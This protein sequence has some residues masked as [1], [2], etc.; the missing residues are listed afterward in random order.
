L[1]AS[2]IVLLGA[3][4]GFTIFLGLP[5]GRVRSPMPRTKVFLNALAIGIL[6]FLLWD[7]LT[8]AWEPGASALAEHRYG[9][10]V[11]YI[12]TMLG[13][14]GLGLMGLVYFDRWMKVRAAALRPEGPGA[15]T[16][17]RPLIPA[18]PGAARARAAE[19]SLLIAVGIGLHNFG[20]GLA[21]GSSAA[22]GRLSLAVLLV[23]GF[24]AHNATEGF[25]IV[26]P[27]SAAGEYPTWGRL[28]LL[29]LIGGGPTFLGTLTGQVVTTPLLGVA[30]L[31]LAAGSI[32]YVVIELLAVARASKLKELVTWAILLGIALGFV[33]DAIVT[34]AGA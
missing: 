12:A 27:L 28:A 14:L 23:I 32:L 3:I 19:L 30:F 34:A 33:T 25:G 22:A 2:Q 13:C 15:A 7:V 11:G 4:A 24:G 21:I 10:A 6:I 8:N 1:P 20:E 5:L 29:G 26:A 31:A 17:H 9:T 16:A 18:G